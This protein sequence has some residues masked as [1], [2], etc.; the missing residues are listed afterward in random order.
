MMPPIATA[1]TAVQGLYARAQFVNDAGSPMEHTFLLWVTLDYCAD[2]PRVTALPQRRVSGCCSWSR[3]AA[4]ET[5]RVRSAVSRA[6][7]AAATVR[8]A[9]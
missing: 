9:A 4:G 7:D 8:C 3:R 1:N 2:S 6:S 5:A